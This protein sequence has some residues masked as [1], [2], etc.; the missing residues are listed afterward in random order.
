MVVF[1]LQARVTLVAAKV[2]QMQMLLV[3]R[4]VVGMVDSST[5]LV[6]G[7]LAGQQV[8]LLLAGALGRDVRASG[9]VGPIAGRR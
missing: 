2:A 1:L 5:G 3:A 8:Q 7:R 4:V 9:C 6:R